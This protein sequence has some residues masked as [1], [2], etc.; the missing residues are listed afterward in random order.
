MFTITL[1]V[2][3]C[4]SNTDCQAYEPASWTANS[5]QEVNQSLEACAKEERRYMSNVIGSYKESDCYVVSN[6]DK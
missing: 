1:Y 2:A 5:I 6:E 3:L 4:F